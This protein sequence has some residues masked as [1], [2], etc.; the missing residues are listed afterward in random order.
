MKLTAVVIVHRSPGDAQ[1]RQNFSI[2]RK[3]GHEA[4]PLPR[5]HRL[6]TVT[7]RG[8]LNMLQ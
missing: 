3:G 6:L 1:V 8:K 2:E 7:G 4:P 5:N